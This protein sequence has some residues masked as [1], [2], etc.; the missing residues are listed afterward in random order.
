MSP[1]SPRGEGPAPPPPRSPVTFEELAA[2]PDERLD[3][4]TGAAL[5]ARD[6]YP[7]VDP[8]QLLGKLDAIAAPLVAGGSGAVA[9]REQARR[10]S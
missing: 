8:V 1:V 4:A 2:M 5:I 9:P 6:A 7:R 3:V 10:V